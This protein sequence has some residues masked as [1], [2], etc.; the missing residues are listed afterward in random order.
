MLRLVM[1]DSSRALGERMGA[2]S[3]H[4]PMATALAEDPRALSNTVG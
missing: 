4:T 3:P 1:A 2:N